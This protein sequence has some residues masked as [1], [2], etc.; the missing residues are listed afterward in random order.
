MWG[1]DGVVGW[2]P[3]LVCKLR[4]HMARGTNK[5]KQNKT[6]TGIQKDLEWGAEGEGREKDGREWGDRRWQGGKDRD[7]FLLS[8][9]P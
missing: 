1:W 7:S 3:A 2:V 9:A 8:A 6:K 4:S 5:N